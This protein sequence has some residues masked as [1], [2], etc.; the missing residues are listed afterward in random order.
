MLSGVM[1]TWGGKKGKEFSS[2]FK[3]TVYRYFESKKFRYQ[4]NKAWRSF[5]EPLQGA[6]LKLGVVLLFQVLNV[7]W[8]PLLKFSLILR[9]KEIIST[10]FWL[11]KSSRDVFFTHLLASPFRFH[12]RKLWLHLQSHERL[13]QGVSHHQPAGIQGQGMEKTVGCFT[14]VHGGRK[15]DTGIDSNKRGSERILRK[16]L[17]HEKLN[18]GEGYSEVVPFPSLELF[19]DKAVIL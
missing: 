15:R 4:T 11:W 16:L 9:S 18:S 14:M 10:V 3:W 12:E 19:L 2:F 1:E 8:A 13:G 17:H 5:T 6:Q 7:F